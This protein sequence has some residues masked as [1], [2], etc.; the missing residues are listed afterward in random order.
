MGC[1]EY[2]ML[3]AHSSLTKLLAISM[4][5]PQDSAAPIFVALYF[6]Y[7]K[8][9]RELSPQIV[10]MIYTVHSKYHQKVLYFF[11]KSIIHLFWL[12]MMVTLEDVISCCLLFSF[13]FLLTTKGTDFLCCWS[14]RAYGSHYTKR[15][16]RRPFPLALKENAF[17]SSR[18]KAAAV[19]AVNDLCTCK[20]QIC[21]LQ[22]RLF[23][24][25]PYLGGK[26]II[27]RQ[28]R[29]VLRVDGYVFNV[30]Q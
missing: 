22:W 5:C 30:P 3:S 21:K 23:K 28:G 8:Y 2:F 29:I 14:L 16:E 7:M 4:W 9:E 27:Y 25:V 18:G 17:R 12:V 13:L 6:K 1:G 15:N 24:C 11:A 26:K 10:Q 19:N 20:K